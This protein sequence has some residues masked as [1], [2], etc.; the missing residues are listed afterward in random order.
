[1]IIV[2]HLELKD[3]ISFSSISSYFRQIFFPI[4]FH[5][6]KVSDSNSKFTLS[7]LLEELDDGSLKNIGSKL[8]SLKYFMEN[9]DWNSAKLLK[10][11]DL[12]LN[13]CPNITEISFPGTMFNGYHGTRSYH[14]NV[15]RSKKYREKH[16]LSDQIKKLFINICSNK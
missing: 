16:V 12:L 11:L 7:N 6:I 10:E 9:I 13:L 8:H 15:K 5:T 1:M 14:S 3:K 2:E 4:D